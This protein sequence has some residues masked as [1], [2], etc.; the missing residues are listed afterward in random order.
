MKKILSIYVE[1]IGWVHSDEKEEI[2]STSIQTHLG[3]FQTSDYFFKG[4]QQFNGKF[5]VSVV[6]E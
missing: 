2:L 6:Y 5:V 3:K 4:G 1:H